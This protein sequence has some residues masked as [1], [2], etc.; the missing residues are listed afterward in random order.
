MCIG[1]IVYGRPTAMADYLLKLL[2]RLAGI[3]GHNAGCLPKVRAINEALPGSSHHHIRPQITC[4][5]FTLCAHW[6][7]PLRLSD[8]LVLYILSW[9]WRLTISGIKAASVLSC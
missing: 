4:A 3:C 1:G 5:L 2:D 7:K 9:T 8:C 6:C